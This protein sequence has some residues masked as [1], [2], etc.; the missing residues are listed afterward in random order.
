M[1]F[2]VQLAAA[3]GTNPTVKKGHV[4]SVAGNVIVAI[5]IVDL[6]PNT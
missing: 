4:N 2:Y 5:H 6:I 3:A 1:T